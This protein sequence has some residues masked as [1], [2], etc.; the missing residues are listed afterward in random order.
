MA[1]N[2]E[3]FGHGSSEPTDNRSSSQIR[4]DFCLMA[5]SS[6]RKVFISW[7]KSFEIL[8]FV[9]QFM[10]KKTSVFGFAIRGA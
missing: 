7:Q 10:A 4:Q 2:L 3:R 6:K 9:V 8:G 5:G 1:K